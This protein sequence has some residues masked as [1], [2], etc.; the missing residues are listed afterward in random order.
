MTA[1]D[2]A[3][4]MAAIDALRSLGL[5]VIVAIDGKSGSGKSTIGLELARRSGGAYIDQDD[6]YS[7][8]EIEQWSLLEASD[9]W[10]RCIDWRRVRSELL[11]PL[12]NGI[13]ASYIPFDWDVMAMG[14]GAPIEIALAEVVILDG[15]Y[16]SRHELQ[17]LID[18]SVL[19]I[20]DEDTRRNRVKERDGADWSEEWFRVWNEAEDCYFSFIRP[21]EHFDLVISGESGAT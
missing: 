8:G 13:P 1:N 17:D 2:L 6:F 7:G 10:D 4:V 21:E 12:R 9:R 14:E 15:T 19:V 18:L 3:K 20:L 11:E 16:A 5:P